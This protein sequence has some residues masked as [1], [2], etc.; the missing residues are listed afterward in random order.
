[1]KQSVKP[2]KSNLMAE[3][4]LG[5][6][7][8]GLSYGIAN[9]TGKIDLETGREIFAL[10]KQHGVH[11]LDTAIAY[12]DAESVLGNIGCSSWDV[13]TK[14]PPVPTDIADI[15][16]W[17]KTEVK[18]SLARL[19]L[20]SLYALLLHHPSDLLGAHSENLLESLLD[21]KARGVVAK[22]GVSIYSADELNQLFT[23]PMIDVVQAP[24][25]IIDRNLMNSGWLTK[26]D[27]HDVEIHTRSTF[28]Q[29]ALVMS[30]A[31][32]PSWL[33]QWAPIFREWDTWV[34]DTGMSRIEACLAHV[35]SYPEIDRIVVGM[36]SKDQTMEILEAL[37]TT[38]LRAPESL[39]SDDEQLINPS[40]WVTT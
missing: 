34:A 11:T 19:K 27:Q 26:L 13:V 38:P 3:I 16:S 18:M 4:A 15:S 21:L 1:L 36:D 33:A 20:P 5:T 8:F 22:L 17:V 12:G 23:L 2:Q 39:S 14:L 32:R 40:K 25:N 24:M 29:G 31:E 37:E 28:L 35:R 9:R 10:A 30:P 7:Q 6:A